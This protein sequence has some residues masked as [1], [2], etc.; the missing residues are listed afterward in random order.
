MYKHSIIVRWQVTSQFSPD[1]I[2]KTWH[3]RY[4]VKLIETRE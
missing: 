3:D 1:E 4:S 2:A